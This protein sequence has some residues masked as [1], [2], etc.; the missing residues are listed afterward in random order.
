MQKK[1]NLNYMSIRLCTIIFLPNGKIKCKWAKG[2]KFVSIDFSCR[3]NR[4][5]D[6]YV[7]F[8]VSGGSN[9]TTGE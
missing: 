8:S 2:E 4:N 9:S 3:N 1:K 5:G 7:S 6:M